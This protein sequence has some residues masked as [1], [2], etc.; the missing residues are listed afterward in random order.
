MCWF[1]ASLK[2]FEINNFFLI[3][4]KREP[5]YDADGCRNGW[6][7][8]YDGDAGKLNDTDET[9]YKKIQIS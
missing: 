6:N 1:F 3:T 5:S 9:N 8:Y 4:Y 2:D 7:H